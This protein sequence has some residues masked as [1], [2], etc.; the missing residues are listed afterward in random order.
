MESLMRNRFFVIKDFENYGINIYGQVKNFKTGRIKKTQING[1]GYYYVQLFEIGKRMT[2]K[3]IHRLLA[4]IFHPNYDKKKC[5]DHIDGDITNNKL[6]NLRWVT[7]EENMQNRKKHSNNRSGITGV[8][9]YK[10]L[11]KWQASITLNGKTKHLGRYEMLHEA[12]RA[13]KY[14]EALHFGEFRRI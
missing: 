6:S 5:V 8:Y 7:H 14:A 13:R 11:Q 9:W 10:T 3:R 12:V 1:H 2:G 4:E